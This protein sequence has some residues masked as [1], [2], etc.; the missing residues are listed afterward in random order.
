MMLF[1]HIPDTE[2]QPSAE[3]LEHNI[4]QWQNWIGNIAAQDKFVSTNQLGY[5]GA[6]LNNKG[7]VTDGPYTEIKEIVGGYVIVKAENLEEA[8]SI[9]E[10]CPIL[11][12][13]GNVEIRNVMQLS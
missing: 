8:I 9:A 13:G 1:R 7:I 10:G 5:E 12:I 3:E 4:K 11:H 2:Y 6:N